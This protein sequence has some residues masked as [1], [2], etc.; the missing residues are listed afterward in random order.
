MIENAWYIN[1][2]FSNPNWIVFGK[3]EIIDGTIVDTYCTAPFEECEMP[4]G[5]IKCTCTPDGGEPLTFR[6]DFCTRMNICNPFVHTID[7]SIIF[8]LFGT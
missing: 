1:T 5:H 6:C 8:F 7:G 2:R 3:M 4:D